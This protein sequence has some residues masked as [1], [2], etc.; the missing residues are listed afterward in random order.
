MVIRFT[1]LSKLTEALD[2]GMASGS[3]RLSASEAFL[4]ISMISGA[5]LYIWQ[6]GLWILRII[7]IPANVNMKVTLVSLSMLAQYVFDLGELH[8]KYGSVIRINPEENHVAD[9][10][11]YNT[12]YTPIE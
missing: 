3:N 6:S 11:F 2:G 8:K 9:A 5:P 1:I 7:E 12:R 4:P 10:D